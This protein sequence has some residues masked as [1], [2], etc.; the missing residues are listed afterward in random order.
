MHFCRNI[1][2]LV[3]LV[4]GGKMVR[5][6]YVYWGVYVCGVRVC[7]WRALCLGV[8]CVWLCLWYVCAHTY[9]QE[10]VCW[11]FNSIICQILRAG[12]KSLTLGWGVHKGHLCPIRLDIFVDGIQW[13]NVKDFA[14]VAL[15]TLKN[16]LGHS[17]L[18][19]PTHWPP[20]S[21]CSF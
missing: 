21:F 13:N 20:G 1:F 14:G 9:V 15:G 3:L 17:S 11:I 18:S 8:C 10:H 6:S 4:F 16:C 2:T 5:V 12:T 7:T 19:S